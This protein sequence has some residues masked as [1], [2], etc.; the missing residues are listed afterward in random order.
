MA[1]RIDIGRGFAA[2]MNQWLAIIDLGYTSLMRTLIT[3]MLF[4]AM[5]VVS[6][7]YKVTHLKLNRVF[8]GTTLLADMSHSKSPRVVDVDFNGNILWFGHDDAKSQI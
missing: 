1:K 5:P 4:A 2:V 6:G 3:L 8:E 7:D